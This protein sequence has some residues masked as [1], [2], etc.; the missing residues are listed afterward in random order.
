[1]IYMTTSLT[2]TQGRSTPVRTVRGRTLAAAAAVAAAVAVPQLFHLLGAFSGAGAS[3]AQALLPMHLPILL[4]GLLAGPAA[5]LVAGALGPVVSFALS[6]MPAAALLPFMVVELAAY[7]AFAGLLAGVRM[8]TLVKVLLA[9]A[10][11]RLARA[12]AVLA[13]AAATGAPSLAVS[14]VWTATV[15]G[16]PGLALQ[17]CLLPLLMFWIER[18]VGRDE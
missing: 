9:Q 18:Q 5:G 4:V 15:A 10:G 11:G 12:G 3:F 16:L 8:P 1:M 13:A 7:G 2:L 6:G 17:W 14:S